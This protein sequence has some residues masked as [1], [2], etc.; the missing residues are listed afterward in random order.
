LRRAPGGARGHRGGRRR[1][2]R[3]SDAAPPRRRQARRGHQI[4]GLTPEKEVDMHVRRVRL[5]AVIATSAALAL[6]ACGGS[7]ST[8][9]KTTVKLYNDKGAWSEYF[10]QLGA[11]SK[12]QIGLA[13]EPVGY[14]DAA[15][16]DAFIKASFRT[17]TKPDLFTWHTG[18]QLK[19][20]VEAGHV[21][22]T[23]ELWSEA[24]AQGY[25]TESLREHYTYDGKQYC[26]PLNI[27]YWVMFYNKKVFDE[28]G[29]QPPKTWADLTTAAA[30]LKAKGITPFYQTADLF[31]F[32]WF[33]H[34]MIGSDPDLYV[35][36][37]TGEA[38]FT[39]PGVVTVMEEWKSLIDSG[40][41]SDPG[42]K[43]EPQELLKSGKVA[44]VPFGTWFNTSMTQAGLKPGTDYGMFLI[45]NLNPA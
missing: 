15:T 31:N 18:G 40:Y 44:M 16:Y 32:V 23:S 21:A 13:M 30:T 24:I 3:A 12:E 45:P 43:T 1:A 7:E 39:D 37:G 41:M 8:E 29:L 34:L 11:L 4:A 27:A 38:K 14:T 2:G 36:L 33:Q 22:D 28:A 17:N 6:S 26:V 20:I 42:D 9:P 19:E 35:K 5:F 25:L 10:K